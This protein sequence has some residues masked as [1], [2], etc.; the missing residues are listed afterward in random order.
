MLDKKNND[1]SLR[2]IGGSSGTIYAY[3]GELH[4]NRHRSSAIMY[5][6]VIF[7]IFTILLPGIAWLVINQEW[8][9]PIPFFDFVYKPWRLYIVVCAIPSLLCLLVLL[10]LPESPKFVLGQGNQVEAISIL[11]QIN[12]WNNGTAAEPLNI[13]EIYDETAS[14]DQNRE[15]P[16]SLWASVW[17]QTAPL[18][19]KP[20][21]KTTI[22]ISVIQFV[23]FA[24]SHG[25]YMWFPNI[26]N[27]IATN[28]LAHP[29]ERVDMCEIVYRTR[30]NIT[31]LLTE[32]GSS[33]EVCVLHITANE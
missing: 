18:F 1:K 13:R 4:N 26:L 17:I 21:L 28:E 15:R 22:L 19:M 7:G 12:R 27:R 25:M 31:A 30:P 2:S 8:S 3:I 24:V 29:G 10:F 6:S 20:Y 32:G 14:A 23:V 33:P 9:L 5:A 16:K 11:E